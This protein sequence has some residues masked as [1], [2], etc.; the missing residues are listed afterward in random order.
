MD[1]RPDA[2][3]RA[4]W[5]LAAFGT[6]VTALGLGAAH[7]MEERG[8]VVT[9]MD[10]QVAW[11]LPHVFAIFLI[12]AASG[13]LNV[14]SV[15]SV[16]GQAAYKARGRL[17]GLLSM[18]MLAGGLM[19]LMLDLGRPERVIVAATNYN[20]RSMFAWNVLLYG[21][22]AAVVALYLWTMFERRFNAW[23]RPAGIAVLVWR[24]VLTAGT[25]SIFAFLV[26]RQ[27][28][29]SA[30]LPPLF[31]V[32][33]FSWGMAVFLVVQA[34][35]Y[36]WNRRT[37]D[38]AVGR[39]LARLLGIFVAASLFLVAV[40]HLTG[41]YFAKQQAFQ[42]FVLLGQGGGGVFALLFWG[43]YVGLG[44]LLPLVLLLH[45]RPGGARATTAAAALVVLSAFAWLYVFIVGGQAFPL[46]I[47]PGRQVS[48]SFADGAVAAYA[49]A[50]PEW[51]L[52]IGGVGAA[53]LLTVVGVRVLDFMPQDDLAEVH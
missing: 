36:G 41:S 10:N 30:L 8:H 19:V 27:A 53:F 40:Q 48:S 12:V 3:A 39:R 45:P 52:G 6:A 46:D 25:G 16:F 1:E 38:P 44:S 42:A 49:P 21:G 20:F 29:G 47:F 13:V 50:W 9:G 28:W 34:A 35:L 26:A 4:F 22:L 2:D 32:M 15:G 43:G 5:A 51:L 17:A 23:S 33:S 37:L 31:I 24:F 7:V 11:G 14:A 18:A